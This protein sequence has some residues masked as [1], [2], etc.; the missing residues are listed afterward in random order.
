[1][2]L[3]FMDMTFVAMHYQSMEGEVLDHAEYWLL[4]KPE[5]AEAFGPQPRVANSTT[6]QHVHSLSPKP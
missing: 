3:G 4:E 5:C 2:G 6:P 1:M